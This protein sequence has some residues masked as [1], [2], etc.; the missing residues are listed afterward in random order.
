LTITVQKMANGTTGPDYQKKK[1][2][3]M[4]GTWLCSKND[5]AFAIG[6]ALVLRME[7]EKSSAAV[8]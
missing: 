1:K 5:A 6:K 4:T 8:S 7:W 3:H 2:K